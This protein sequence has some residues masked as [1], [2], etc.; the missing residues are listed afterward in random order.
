[1][2]P[3]QFGYWVAVAFTINYIVGTGF[4]TIPW[5][6]SQ[7]GCFL[8]VLVLSLV[9][10][11]S[12][13]AALFVLETMARADSVCKSKEHGM[14]MLPLKDHLNGK[15]FHSNNV[16]NKRFEVTELCGIFLGPIGRQIYTAALGMYLYCTLLAYA[17]VFSR[18][19]STHFNI[20]EQSHTLYL[21]L[22]GFLVIPMSCAELSEQIILQV[23]LAIGRLFLFLVM[24]FSVSFAFFIDDNPF[25]GFEE[26]S[27]GAFSD[28]SLNRLHIML[29]IL[30]F[31]NIFHHS[32]PAL[33]A[34]V[35]DKSQLSSIFTTTIMI[36]YLSYLTLGV[37]VS[38]YFGAVTPSSA[39]LLWSAY[40]TQAPSRFCTI[41]SAFVVIFP[42]IG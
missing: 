6:F 21:C 30:V 13:A 28:V 41:V 20:G 22:Y 38:L 5:A 32:I 34:P 1:V 16:G 2:E 26:V 17:T 35:A 39:N 27:H 9:T 23:T 11:L 15:R 37:L 42:A 3:H 36:C 25:G 24:V 8:S 7:A 12:I 10:Y 19:F 14:E 33:S 4:L 18:A 29:P 31:A 40:M